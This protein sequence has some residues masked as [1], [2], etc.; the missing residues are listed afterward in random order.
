[1]QLT[2]YAIFVVQ[3]RSFFLCNLAA[4]MSMYAPRLIVCQGDTKVPFRYLRIVVLFSD[5]LRNIGEL[6]VHSVSDLLSD[7]SNFFWR[8]GLV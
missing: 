1:M 3:A 6:D 7:A 8:L 2:Q 5:W 4:Y